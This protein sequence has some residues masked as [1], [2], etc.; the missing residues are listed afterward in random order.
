MDELKHRIE[1]LE[2]NQE[3]IKV[4][5]DRILDILHKIEKRLIGDIE[6]DAPGIVDDLRVLRRTTESIDSRLIALEKT[7]VQARVDFLEKNVPT[8]VAKVEE[9]NKY[10]FVLYGGIA[11]AAFI[12]TKFWELMMG[13]K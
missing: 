8:V 1:A 7:N 10:R 6:A 4:Q 2:H 5:E 11:V 3:Q 9:L 12:F 13:K